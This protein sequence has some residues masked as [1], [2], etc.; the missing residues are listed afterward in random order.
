MNFKLNV[1]TKI[2]FLNLILLKK[3]PIWAL[4]LPLYIMN[5]HATHKRV[6]ETILWM[7]IDVE[8][9]Q[10]KLDVSCCGLC[11]Y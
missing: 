3:R 10:V 8:W 6:L 11:K 9:Q 5:V 4:G 1:N 2:N 7:L